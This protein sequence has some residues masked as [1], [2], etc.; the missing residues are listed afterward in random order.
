MRT[1]YITLAVT[2]DGKS[3]VL[4]PIAGSSSNVT[5]TYIPLPGL[6][7]Q[8]LNEGS[9]LI[10]LMLIGALCAYHPDLDRH[11]L[12][13]DKSGARP[14]RLTFDNRPEM[15]PQRTGLGVEED[16]AGPAMLVIRTYHG[17]DPIGEDERH[18]LKQLAE[19]GK[20]VAPSFIAEI[21]LRKLAAMHPEVLLAL[22]PK[23][24]I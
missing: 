4:R 12:A 10:G 8:G 13:P 6:Q 14:Y 9:A 3:L 5:A 15:R 16:E 23:I 11:A 21:M 7:E 1:Y 20:D 17:H 22:F 24:K 2:P 18:S 19:L